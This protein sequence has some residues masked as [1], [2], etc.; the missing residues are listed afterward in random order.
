VSS[1]FRSCVVASR[2]PLCGALATLCLHACGR[3]DIELFP[4]MPLAEPTRSSLPDTTD[5]SSIGPKEAGVADARDVSSSPIGECG[6]AVPAGLLAS[7][8]PMGWNGYNAFGGEPELNEEKLKTIVEAMVSSGMQ[9]AG[10]QYVNLDIGWQ[11]ERSATGER[12]FDA[13]RLPGGIQALSEWIHARE[14]SFGIYS[15]IQD[16][17]ENAGGEGFEAMDVADYVNWG[18]DYIKYVNCNPADDFEPAIAALAMALTN[19]ERPIVLSLAAAPFQEW[20]RE[21]AQVWRVSGDARPTWRSIVDA[22]D[23]VVPL[24][25]Y[26]RPGAFND[27]DMLEIGNGALTEAEQRV[28][29]S[30]WSI[31]SAPLLAGN[32]LTQMTDIERAILTN[33]RVIALNQDPLGLQATLIRTAGDVE[34]LAK[35]L[36][37]CGERAV[38]LWN[39]GTTSTE[40]F[41]AWEELWLEPEVAAVWDLWSDSQIAVGPTGFSV[42]VAG[43]DAMALRVEGVE[44]PLPKGTVALSDLRWSYATNGFGPVELD[45]TNGEAEP[46]DGTPIQLRG[47]TYDKGLGVHAPALVR[48]RL[49]GAC[50]RFSAEVG[51]DDDQTLGSAQFEVWADGERLFQSPVLTPQSPAV[52]VDVDVENRLDLRLFVGIGGDEYAHDHGIWAGATL[53]CDP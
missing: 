31:L 39:R 1:Y 29:F 30:V 18:V 41:V 47:T 10:Y 28:Q 5:A 38:V 9:A 36:A 13:D 43:H 27:P 35:P 26:A 3:E 23:S 42:T 44:L 11:G 8:P 52:R 14:F 53:E 2:G 49:G 7:R 12:I 25:A 4:A 32:D 17:D 40:V 51:L 21:T 22:I 50:S 46:L 24:A 48:Y 37:P 20:M 45:R 19:A 15:H 16:C 34:I 33:P 6:A